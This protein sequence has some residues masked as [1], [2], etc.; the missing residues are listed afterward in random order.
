MYKIF[1]KKTISIEK[2]KKN[3]I[4]DVIYC[5]HGLE[6]HCKHV[7]SAQTDTLIQ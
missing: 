5:V 3:Y 6:K 1:I 2:F 7:S 4:V